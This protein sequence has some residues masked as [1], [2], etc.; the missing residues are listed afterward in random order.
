MGWRQITLDV[1]VE[2]YASATGS[3]YHVIRRT[4]RFDPLTLGTA[5]WGLDAPLSMLAAHATDLKLPFTCG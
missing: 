4:A 3:P 2:L 5:A 1:L